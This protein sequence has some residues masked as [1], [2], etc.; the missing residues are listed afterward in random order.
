MLIE[1]GESEYGL[2][3]E[4]INENF[5]NFPI[6]IYDKRNKK[7]LDIN[8]INESFP[9]DNYPHNKS[10]KDLNDSPI[11]DNNLLSNS[12]TLN[13]LK[14]KT[15]SNEDRHNSSFSSLF[16]LNE[17]NEEIKEFKSVFLISIN[18]LMKMFNLKKLDK[19]NNKLI[20]SIKNIDPYEYF[21]LS[22]IFL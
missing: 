15:K 8:T 10:L 14:E 9:K 16:K 5:S 11:N 3:N 21:F 6:E 4:T 1:I 22:L 13:N 18:K 7:N 2:I 19:K 20:N 17:E 12:K